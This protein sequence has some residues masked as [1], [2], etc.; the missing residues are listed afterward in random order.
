MPPG[1]GEAAQSFQRLRGGATAI[2]R[3]PVNMSG[4]LSIKATDK[5]VRRSCLLRYLVGAIIFTRRDYDSSQCG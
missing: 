3:S 1:A 4:M 5:A 2:G